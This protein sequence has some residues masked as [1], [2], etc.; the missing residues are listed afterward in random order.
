[1]SEYIDR[2][3]HEEFCKRMEEEHK[4]QNNRITKLEDTVLKIGSLATSVEKLACNMEHMLTEQQQQGIRLET[5][6][7]RD[8]EMWRK[9]VGY[10][11]SAIVGGIV[12]FLMSKGLT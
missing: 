1:M 3:E 4:R 5:L 6:E 7:E 2:H 9:V 8:G 11:L 10:A 12:T